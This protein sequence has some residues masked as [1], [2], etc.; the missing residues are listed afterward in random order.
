MYSLKFP[1]VTYSCRIAEEQVDATN[2]SGFTALHYAGWRGH[3][4]VAEMLKKAK[5]DPNAKCVWCR[6]NL[7][8]NILF[9][10]ILKLIRNLS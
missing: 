8:I 2:S 1:I 10:S 9:L 3:Q 7:V 6:C 4:K 5:A